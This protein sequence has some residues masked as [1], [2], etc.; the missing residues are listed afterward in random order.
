MNILYFAPIA[1]GYL[2]QRP[3]YLAQEL[4][5]EHVVYYIE[6]TVSL[7]ASLCH[8]DL[9]CTYSHRKITNR[10]HVIRLDGRFS[11]PYR[12][13]YA[14]KWGMTAL[15]EYIQ[16]LC[17]V[18]TID[19]LWIG[20]PGWYGVAKH[21]QGIR[22]VYDIMD[23]YVHLVKDQKTR[24]YIQYAAKKL[25][26]TADIIFTSAILFYHKLRKKRKNVFLIPNALPEEYI[27]STLPNQVTADKTDAKIVFGYIGVIAQ[28][29]DVAAVEYLAAQNKNKVILA[30]PVSI[31]KIQKKNVT[32]TGQIP[33]E[34][35][36]AF[37]K[38]CDVCLYPFLPGPVLNSVNPVKIY[39]YL[40]FN[41]PVIARRSMETKQLA[42]RLHLYADLK[43]LE[44]ILETGIKQPFSSLA[45]YQCFTAAN[46]WSF[47]AV[48]VAKIL[49][50]N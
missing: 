8:K 28:W 22:V 30:G 6:P 21:F 47:R 7:A 1:F 32:Y 45:E 5:K 18:K 4:A 10:L 33:K 17:T 40:A 49:E 48:Q 16:L 35:I 9:A 19:L 14:D 11:L 37:I 24:T 25:E 27:Q 15:A 23:D 2:K 36:P 43:G 20:Y 29:F 39:E 31:P 13:K 42:G 44:N 34:K 3:Q 38:K 12:L 46:S 50:E 41:K 26:D